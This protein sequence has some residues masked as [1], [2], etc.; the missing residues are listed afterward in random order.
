[1]IVF[2]GTVTPGDWLRNFQAWI[3]PI[4]HDDLGPVH[5]GF[6]SKMRT[7]EREITELVPSRPLVICGHSLGVWSG[8][9]SQEVFVE[10]AVSGLAS[11]V[12]G[13]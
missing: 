6:Y 5:A 10:V 8:R 2:R 11:N 3:E 1:M 4:H 13:L 7:V 9:A 12:S